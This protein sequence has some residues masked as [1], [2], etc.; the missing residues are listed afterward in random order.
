MLKDVSVKLYNYKGNIYINIEG[1]DMCVCTF[2]ILRGGCETVEQAHHSVKM[3]Y[4]NCSFHMLSHLILMHFKHNFHHFVLMLKT[5]KVC[6]C[7][8]SNLLL[9]SLDGYSKLSR[10]WPQLAFLR[11]SSTSVQ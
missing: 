10:I 3:K 6:L 1:I 7:L 5:C 9:N 2:L 4:V 8:R 11:L